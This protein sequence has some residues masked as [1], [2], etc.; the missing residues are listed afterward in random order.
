MFSTKRARVSWSIICNA[1]VLLDNT[2]N[3]W[4]GTRDGANKVPEAQEVWY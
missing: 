3:F 4:H 2:H 1:Q